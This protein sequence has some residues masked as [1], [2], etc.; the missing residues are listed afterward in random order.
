M[1]SWAF[2]TFRAMSSVGTRVQEPD[3]TNHDIQNTFE[4]R[5]HTVFAALILCFLVLLS[6]GSQMSRCSGLDESTKLDQEA[7][8]LTES[9]LTKFKLLKMFD[10]ERFEVMFEVMQ[11]DSGGANEIEVVSR[12]LLLRLHLGHQVQTWQLRLL[13]VDQFLLRLHLWGAG[14]RRHNSEQTEQISGTRL[15]RKDGRRGPY[16]EL[17]VPTMGREDP[18]ARR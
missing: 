5:N 9:M 8:K 17:Q 3:T 6:V 18:E 4:M 14:V 12:P 11:F 13:L 1:S 15:S 2:F 10:F 7:K 16:F